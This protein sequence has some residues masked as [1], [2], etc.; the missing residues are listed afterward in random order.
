VNPVGP[1]SVVDVSTAYRFSRGLEAFL[2]IQNLFDRQYIA[3]N[4]SQPLLGTPFTVF[5]GVRA[6]LN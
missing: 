6:R 1:S 3:D 2:A 5:A 4:F